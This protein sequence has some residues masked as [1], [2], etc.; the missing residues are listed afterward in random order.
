[1]GPTLFV[2]AMSDLQPI[3][4]DNKY[5]K[6]ADD[7]VIFTLKSTKGML[8]LEIDNIKQ[9]ATRHNLTLNS[10]KTKAVHFTCHKAVM[11]NT[12]FTEFH[13]TS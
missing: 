7:T 8:D 6:Y 13:N 5:I 3:C 11:K 4:S 10:S 12:Q 2:V 1:M 9:W